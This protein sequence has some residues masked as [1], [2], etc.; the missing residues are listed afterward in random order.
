MTDKRKEQK[1]Q[2]EMIKDIRNRLASGQTTTFK[3]RNILNMY[4]KKQAKKAKLQ[5]A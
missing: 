1:A 2:Y 4:N 5:S 3:E